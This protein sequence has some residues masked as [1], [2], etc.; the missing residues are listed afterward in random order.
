[1]KNHNLFF[2]ISILTIFFLNIGCNNNRSRDSE[3]IDED[4]SAENGYEDG[5]HCAEVTYYNPNTGTNNTYTLE[6]EVE[7]N[8]LITI[9][10]SNGGWLDEDHFSAE[11]L[12]DNG[13]CSFTSDKGYEYEIQIIGKDCGYTDETSFQNDI[14]NDEESVTCP[15]CGAEKDEYDDYC[16]N[17]KR[18]IEDEEQNTCSR[19]G[20]YEYGVYGGL[21]S[22]C[23]EDD[24]AAE[25][26]EY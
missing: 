8:E 10:W 26:E 1:M 6:V 3:V 11:T 20:S 19:C 12:D 17:C 15:K 23:K 13:Y 14:Q 16:Y 24:Q 18:E 22:N 7:N 5:T 9:Y 21:C 2:V 4:Y 25:N